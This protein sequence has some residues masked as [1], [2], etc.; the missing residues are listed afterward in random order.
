MAD[1]VSECM[2][3]AVVIHLHVRGDAINVAPVL[4]LR[5]CRATLPLV[6]AQYSGGKLEV[7]SR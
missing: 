1:A 4:A 3:R 6:V 2:K 7:N 5:G